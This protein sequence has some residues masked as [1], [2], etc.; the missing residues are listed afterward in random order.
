[1]ALGGPIIPT[2]LIDNKKFLLY[3]ATTN[4]NPNNK[5]V[6]EIGDVVDGATP[7][8]FLM[9]TYLGGI[10]SNFQDTAVWDNWG[11]MILG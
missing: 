4:N 9:G 11:G 8:G 7:N 2:I 10:P 5:C 1:M 3:K 6:L